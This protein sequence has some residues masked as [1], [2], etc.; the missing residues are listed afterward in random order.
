MPPFFDQMIEEPTNVTIRVVNLN[1][2]TS[3]N[4][5]PYTYLPNGEIFH[6]LPPSILGLSVFLNDLSLSRSQN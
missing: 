2:E 5:R 3:S 4:P 6:A 1:D